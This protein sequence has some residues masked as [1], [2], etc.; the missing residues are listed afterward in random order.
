MV[1]QVRQSAHTVADRALRSIGRAMALLIVL[2]LLVGFAVQAWTAR[3]TLRLQALAQASRLAQRSVAQLERN[4]SASVRREPSMQPLQAL[5]DELRPQSLTLVDDAGVVQFER[6]LPPAQVSA[7]AAID[8]VLRPNALIAEL[9][10]RPHAQAASPS[11][12]RIEV[13][14]P[15][16]GELVWQAMLQSVAFLATGGLVLWAVVFWLLKRLRR[17]VGSMSLRM[18]EAAVSRRRSVPAKD[19]VSDQPDEV[20]R[21]QSELKR[22]TAEL[23]GLRAAAL[24][25]PLTGLA[26]REPFMA[27]LEQTLEG[28]GAWP[29]GALLLMRVRDLSATNRRLGREGAD[30]LLKTVAA[31]MLALLDA[32]Q[33]SGGMA[34]RLNGADFALLLP[35]A[36]GANHKGRSALTAMRE[37][38]VAL[39]PDAGM[40]I[41]AVDLTVG[42]TAVKA[43]TMGD[44]TLAEALA[45]GAFAVAVRRHAKEHPAHNEA[46]WLKMLMDAL[47]H[48]RVRLA[49]YPVCDADGQVL[50]LDCPMR[51]QC[52]LGGV[53]EGADHWLAH[54][55]RGQCNADFD[56]LAIQL[57]L[58]AIIRDGR[59]R[60]V[61]VSTR[62]MTSADFMARVTRELESLPIGARGLWIDLPE[63]MALQHHTLVQ[64]AARRWRPLGVQLALEHAGDRLGQI[65]HL[66]YLGLHSIRVD[67]ALVA[68][69]RGPAHNQ[70]RKHLKG[71]V[72]LVH[73]AGLKVTAESVVSSAELAAVWALGFDAASGPALRPR[74]ELT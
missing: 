45:G 16:A 62:S 1:N 73:E 46:Q 58:D 70:A 44:E 29:V 64:E 35:G 18:A 56:L 28:E 38:L 53:Y 17:E 5:F 15:E 26:R 74:R 25:D 71:I 14:M 31:R 37:A 7:L 57:A 39:D 41:A 32:D 4:T 11:R 61:N 8:K 55:D 2:A 21:V 63:A 24:A 60:C 65:D 13:A 34:A 59:Q 40:A 20:Q 48:R 68:G 42:H 72:A 12:L 33:S 23:D 3:E 43:M 10:A 49:E 51:V 67:G 47:V 50:Y 69:L 19:N 6:H 66:S 22:K 27:R 52:V 30:R 9:P 36:T 54:A